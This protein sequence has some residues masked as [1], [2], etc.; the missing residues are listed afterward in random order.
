MASSAPSPGVAGP[1]VTL[2]HRW[3]GMPFGRGFN[4]GPLAGRPRPEAKPPGALAVP[5]NATIVRQF[6]DEVLNRGEI[7]GGETRCRCRKPGPGRLGGAISQGDP[8]R[9]SAGKLN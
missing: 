2:S 9:V 6:L 7:D 3:L 5:D 1:L 4:L 8:A